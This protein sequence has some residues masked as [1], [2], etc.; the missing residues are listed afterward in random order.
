LLIN[1][2]I[3]SDPVDT[4]KDE[5]LTTTPQSL[6]QQPCHT[7][8]TNGNSDPEAAL[9]REDSTLSTTDTSSPARTSLLISSSIHDDFDAEEES[10]LIQIPR[11]GL[12]LRTITS[13]DGN[14]VVQGTARTDT[15][16]VVPGFCT[17]CLSGYD[18]GQDIAWSSNQTC[19]HC[20]HTVCME[21]WLTNQQHG[22]TEGPICPCCRRDFV[23]DPFDLVISQPPI[24]EEGRDEDNDNNTANQDCATTVPNSSSLQINWGDNDNPSI[25]S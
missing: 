25:N 13:P 2:D 20:F 6:E 17:I 23:I 4:G 16:R 22:A 7:K 5:V 11:P 18:V 19:D 1:N 21:Q 24:E 10:T 8:Q 12:V 14:A 15:A 3:A 9:L